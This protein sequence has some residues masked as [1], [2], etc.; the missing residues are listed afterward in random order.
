MI[1]K[2]LSLGMFHQQRIVQLEVS[3]DIKKAQYLISSYQCE[4]DIGVTEDLIKSATL[5]MMLK[6]VLGH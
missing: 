5:S 3:P 1:S 2:E 6:V 4:N